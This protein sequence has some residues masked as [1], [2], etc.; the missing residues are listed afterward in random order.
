[1]DVSFKSSLGF[2]LSAGPKIETS[3][4]LFHRQALRRIWTTISLV[5][6]SLGFSVFGILIIVHRHRADL[7]GPSGNSFVAAI[8]G[9][10]GLAIG[11]SFLVAAFLHWRSLSGP[12]GGSGTRL[13]RV[14]AA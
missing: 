13:H 4:R 7:P 14:A 2:A 12:S 8:G 6:L 9:L 3:K 1:M 11:I 10:G 5:N